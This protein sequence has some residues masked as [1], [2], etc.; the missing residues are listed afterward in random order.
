MYTNTIWEGD[1]MVSLAAQNIAHPRNKGKIITF[2]WAKW[3][4]KKAT[5]FKI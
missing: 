1:L 5:H 4:N 3:M 2:L